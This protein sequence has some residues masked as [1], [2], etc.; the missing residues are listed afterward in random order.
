TH[1]EQGPILEIEDKNIGIVT[2]AQAQKWYEIN[3]LGME[4][5]AGPTPMSNRKD[6]L[7][8]ASEI[9][10]LVNS[11]GNDFQPGGCATCGVLEIGSPSRNVIPGK[12]FLTIDFRHPENKILNEMDKK[13]RN[14]IKLIEKNNKVEIKIKQILELKSNVFNKSIKNI[15]QDVTE[16]LNY[17]SKEIVSGAG[18]DAVNINAIAPTAMIFIPCIDG[19]SHNEVENV[20][21]EDVTKGAQVLLHSMIELADNSSIIIDN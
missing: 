3:I 14:T 15:I 4:A 5:H 9:V 13:L 18:H 19:I 16:K 10:L 20:Y 17:S 1:I 11:I 7:V 6:A 2:G 12:C 21:K 8:A